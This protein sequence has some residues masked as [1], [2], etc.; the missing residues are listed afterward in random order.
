MK[1]IKGKVPYHL[2]PPHSLEEVAKAFDEGAGKY[3]PWDWLNMDPEYL[4]AAAIRHLQEV[5]KGELIDSP[6]G[7]QHA[8]KAATS[9][10]MVAEILRIQT[11]GQPTHIPKETT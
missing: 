11:G 5:R 1:D 6:T 10:M 7:L 4:I 3:E 8:S 9:C 2:V